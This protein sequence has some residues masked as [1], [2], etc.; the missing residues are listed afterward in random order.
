MA[1]QLLLNGLKN[2]GQGAIQLVPPVP[3]FIFDLILW[4]LF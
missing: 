2:L 4:H 1:L 3:N